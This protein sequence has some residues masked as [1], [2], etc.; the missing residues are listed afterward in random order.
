VLPSLRD[1]SGSDEKAV[2][3]A[4]FRETYNR[5]LVRYRCAI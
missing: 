4:L 1:L 3:A 5:M 2:I